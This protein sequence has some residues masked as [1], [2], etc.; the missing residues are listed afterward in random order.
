MCSPIVQV[1]LHSSGCS[2]SDS[3]VGA[4]SGGGS[5][6]STVS[7]DN[8][9]SKENFRSRRRRRQDLRRHAQKL[10]PNTRDSACG[11]L[12]VKKGASV[13]LNEKG[14]ARYSGVVH[15]GNVWA[16]PV[17]AASIAEKRRQNIRSVL[18]WG[19][20]EG[21]S[22]LFPTF[23]ASHTRDDSL[24]DLLDS[25]Y[26]A[27]R[28]FK[29]SRPFRDFK[30]ASGYLDSITG[31]DVTW[32][33]LN[34][35]H[36]HQHEFWM[37]N[38]SRVSDFDVQ[39]WNDVLE[40]QWIKEL[41]KKG[42]KGGVGISF[43]M[44]LLNLDS[45]NG[46]DEYL[47][48]VGTAADLSSELV[49]A[50]TKAGFK[51][52]KFQHFTPIELLARAASGDVRSGHLWKEYVQSY[53]GRRQLVFGRVIMRCYKDYFGTVPGSDFEV[54]KQ[55]SAVKPDETVVIK[56]EPGRL[57]AVWFYHREIDVLEL[58]EKGLISDASALIER[59]YDDLCEKKYLDSVNRLRSQGVFSVV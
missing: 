59:S 12:P 14:Q 43:K 31:K 37:C 48:K 45:A 6:E 40:G 33:E 39:H 17:C 20:K 25:F 26:A 36:P 10:R 16:C 27:Q 18:E 56:I 5:R 46:I 29:Q 11:R 4:A 34:G 2:C 54:V 58:V 57:E 8:I 1:H 53:S 7:V 41:D 51:D 15:C 52:Y 30:L 24:S 23:T 3:V 55:E 35:W 49:G 38:L 32:G 44:K 42:L 50:A 21:F 47:G 9:D 22:F 19:N 28:S 13:I